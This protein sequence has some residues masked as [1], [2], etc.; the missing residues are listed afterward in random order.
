MPGHGRR[1]R[2]LVPSFAAAATGYAA[3]AMLGAPAW[4]MPTDTADAPTPCWSDRIAVTASPAQAAVGHRATT[5]VFSLAGGA[6]PCTL[7]GYPGVDSGAGGPVIHAQPTLRG[8]MG[9]LPGGAEVPPTVILSLSTQAQAVV[10][11]IAIDANGDPCP[12]YSE[13]LVNPPDTTVVLTVPATI[14]ACALQVHP[15][16]PV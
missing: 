13:L 5:L 7:T 15:V 10:E 6:E 16:T 14:D 8:Y 4:A 1:T 2:R 11:G 3:I 12:T 9:G